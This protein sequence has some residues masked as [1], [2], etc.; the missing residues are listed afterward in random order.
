MTDTFRQSDN[1]YVFPDKPELYNLRLLFGLNMFLL[2]ALFVMPQYFGLHLGW[3]ITCTRLANILITIYA[4]LNYRVFNLFVK[5]FLRCSVMIPL[6]LYLFVTFYTMA[7]RAD[8]NAFMLPFLEILTFFMLV[9][10]IRYVLGIKRT[11]KV[12]IGCAYFLGFYG[13]VEFVAGQSLFLKFLKTVPTTVV[14]MYRSGHYRIMGPCGHALGYGLLLILFVAIACIDY[15]KDEMYLY[16]RPILLVVLIVNVFLTGSRSTLA[17]VIIEAAL[18][19]IFSHKAQRE[20]AILY[21]VILVFALGAF[22]LVGYKTKIGSYMVLQIATLVD[23]AFGTQFSLQFGA[24][25]NRLNDSEYYRQ[26]LPQIFKLD[27]LNPLLGRG[28]K[29]TFA[30]TIYDNAGNSINVISVDN[31]YINQYIKYAY[32]GMISY[33]LYILVAVKSMISGIIKYKS[34]TVKVLMIGFCCYF[35]NLWWV[36][37]IQTLKFSY[38]FAALFFAIIIYHKDMEIKDG[39]PN[40]G[41]GRETVSK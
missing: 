15:E 22:M 41:T 25:V 6:M 36:D 38:A 23:S 5:T 13:L 40:E 27:W 1:K 2:V 30:A 28:L 16:K 11:I 34:D 20:K 21:S 10:A 24:E 14:N 8:V 37:A 39:F 31:Y 7:L 12:I 9:F 32:P 4:L 33:C 17:L 18:I 29:R 35:V 26:F 19:I 3:D